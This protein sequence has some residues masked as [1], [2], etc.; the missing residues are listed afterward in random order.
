MGDR[1]IL[2]ER[3]LDHLKG[4]APHG[5]NKEQ[6]R[7]LLLTDLDQDGYDLAEVL[8]K[9]SK[10]KWIYL[11][12]RTYTYITDAKIEAITKKKPGFKQDVIFARTGVL[13]ESKAGTKTAPFTDNWCKIVIANPDYQKKIRERVVGPTHEMFRLLARIGYGDVSHLPVDDQPIDIE[14]VERV[15][16]RLSVLLHADQE[17]I[18]ALYEELNDES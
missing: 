17:G 16:K 11:Y 4:K 7:E 14:E 10:E 8:D 1:E 2:R 6:M 3:V 13:P 9:L 12:Y 15:H 5:S 18:D